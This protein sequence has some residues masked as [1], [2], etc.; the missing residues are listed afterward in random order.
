MTFIKYSIEH[1][2]THQF[3]IIKISKKV[4]FKCNNKDLIHLFVS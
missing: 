3:H 2:P 4:L 1:L